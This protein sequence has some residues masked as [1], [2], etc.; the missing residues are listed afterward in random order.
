VDLIN[1]RIDVA[2]RV[3]TQLNSDAE[4]IMRTLGTSH[5]ILVASPALARRAGRISPR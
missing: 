3:R 2:L 1:E 5:R 4:L